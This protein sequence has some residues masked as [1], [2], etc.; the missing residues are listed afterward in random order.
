V[1]GAASGS[2]TVV[3]QMQLSRAYSCAVPLKRCLLLASP[4]HDTDKVGAPR[5]DAPPLQLGRR[6]GAQLWPC[7]RACGGP[8]PHCTGHAPDRLCFVRASRGDPGPVRPCV[9]LLQQH[10][11]S[12][13]PATLPSPFMECG[14]L[15][16]LHTQP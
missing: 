12:F 16:M 9:V 14:F 10:H 8:A 3:S 7:V 11:A 5:A 13:R 15:S 6:R 4:C 2:V 1:P